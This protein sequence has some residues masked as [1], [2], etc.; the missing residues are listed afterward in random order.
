MVEVSALTKKSLPDMDALYI[1]GGF[2]ETNSIALAENKAFRRS[3]LDA[4]EA[5]LPVYA[6]CGGLMYLGESLLLGRKRYPMVGVFPVTFSLERKPQA[7]GYTVISVSRT[8]PFYA[9]GAVLKGH[10]FHYSKVQEFGRKEKV[11]FAFRMSRGQGIID[12]MD[13]VCYKNVLATYTHIHAYGTPEWADGLVK[14]AEI[15]KRRKLRLGN[16]G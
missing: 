8:N 13:G 3:L 16:E 5:G 1:G 10:E 15:F 2:P 4:I 11:R 7:H 14:K 9:K 12:G 6:E